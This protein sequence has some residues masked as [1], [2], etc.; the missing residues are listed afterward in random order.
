MEKIECPYTYPHRSR[1][2]KVSYI[3]G[4]GGYYSRDGRF[5]IEFNVAAY[6]VDFDFE[7]IWKTYYEEMTPSEL[8]HDPDA[9][10]AYYRLAR[11]LYEK[12][13]DN[14]WEWGQ[15]DACRSIDE[16]DTHRMLWDGTAVDVTLELHGRQG[17][18]LVL[19]AFE[20]YSFRGMSPDDLR[21]T[22]MTQTRPDGYSHV[23]YETLR[24]GNTWDWTTAEVDLLY[25]YV[26][27]CEIDFT[28]A[29]ASAEIEYQGASCF[30]NNIVNIEWENE[31]QRLADHEA[32]V[33]CAQTLR[34]YLAE[35]EG[36]AALRM[37]HTLSHAAGV[38]DAEM[39]APD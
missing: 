10:T 9:C 15:E 16:D 21:D 36:A 11:R 33:A 38:S 2:A 14:L 35:K 6:G 26:R 39:K 37:L 8:K 19:S 12:H 22:L 32:V 18:H 7:H 4:I 29:K 27:Q 25:R 13:K 1:E 24:T 17:K 30:F 3:C 31:K 28:P 34:Q 23:E 5:P 20:G